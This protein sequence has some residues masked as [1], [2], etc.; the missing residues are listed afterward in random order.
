MGQPDS[1]ADALLGELEIAPQPRIVRDDNSTRAGTSVVPLKRQDGKALPPEIKNEKPWHRT[2]AYLS[3]QGKPTA[4][5][6]EEF[7]KHPDTIRLIKRQPWFEDLC[8]RLAAEHFDND[9]TKMVEGADTSAVLKLES[10]M[11]DGSESTQR[12]SA[13]KLLDLHF[14]N[15]PKE[16]EKVSDDPQQELDIINR[17]IKQLEIE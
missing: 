16:A 6:A 1:F 17:E 11:E 4:E 8:A 9:V 13:A 14:A 15:K 7:G 12:F 5:L 3:L 10:L 2:L